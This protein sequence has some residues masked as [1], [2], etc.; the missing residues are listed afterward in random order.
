MKR[1]WAAGAFV[2]LG[3]WL[4]YCL[5]YHHGRQ[6]EQAAWLGTEVVEFDRGDGQLER[7]SQSLDPAHP[8]RIK[9]VPIHDNRRFGI[10]YSNPHVKTGYEYAGRPPMNAPDPRDMLVR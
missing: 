10:Y 3:L 8:G 9:L 5:G 4:G 7:G 2:V 6:D 1:I